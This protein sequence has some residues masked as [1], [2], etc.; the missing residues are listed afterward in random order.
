MKKIMTVVT[1]PV[2]VVQSEMWEIIL[3]IVERRILKWC[4]NWKKGAKCWKCH[5]L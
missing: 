5:L 1:C 4:I 2:S 3:Y